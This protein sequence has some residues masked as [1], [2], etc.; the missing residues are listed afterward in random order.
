MNDLHLI[1]QEIHE[2][3]VEAAKQAAKA[4]HQ[5]IGDRDACGFAWVKVPNVRSNSRL[6]N[7]MKKAGLYKDYTGALALWN[8]SKYPTQSI[9]VLEAGANAYAKV[10]SEH[11]INAYAQSRLD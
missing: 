2:K 7:A 1:F 9:S 10:L 5:V 4:K 11:G 8:P 3:A 6:G